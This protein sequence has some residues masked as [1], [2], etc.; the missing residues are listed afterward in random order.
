MVV[1]LL[2]LLLC[3]C[4]Q[5]V[6]GEINGA[7]G[8]IRRR[9]DESAAAEDAATTTTAIPRLS[10]RVYVNQFPAGSEHLPMPDIVLYSIHMGPIKY[11][12]LELTLESMRSNPKV[13]FVLINILEDATQD[14]GL[15]EAVA[16]R[17]VSNFYP[18]HQSIKEFTDRVKVVLD[19]NVP[20]TLE[21]YYKMCDYKPTVAVLYPE[22]LHK[23]GRDYKYWGYADMDVLWGNFTRFSHLFQGEYPVVMSGWWHSTGALALFQNEEWSWNLFRTSPKYIELLKSKLYYNLDEAGS[24]TNRENLKD[25]CTETNGGGFNCPHAMNTLIH[26]HINRNKKQLNVGKMEWDHVFLDPQDVDDWAGPVLWQ[27]GAL[28]VLK[29]SEFFPPGRQLLFFHRP[30]KQLEYPPLQRNE[31]INDAVK[32]GYFLPQFI[33]LA[34]SQICKHIM[35]R[36][37]HETGRMKWFTP[38]KASCF[39]GEYNH[40]TKPSD[41]DPQHHYNH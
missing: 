33:P 10:K 25:S 28:T 38:Y 26:Q 8:N 19:I 14:G 35:E 27:N 2:F 36:S 41:L 7:S 34:S 13:D 3:L 12:Y 18:V 1:F 9:N 17:G 20:F 39:G 5:G 16:R 37:H 4:Q 30:L 29:G 11:D 24:Q 32:H 21:W 22:L 40:P 23:A 6:H 15:R 31:I